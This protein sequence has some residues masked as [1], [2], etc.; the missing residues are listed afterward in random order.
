MINRRHTR[1]QRGAH[2]VEL[3]AALVFG[4]PLLILII[5]VALECT[6]FYAIK[7][8]MD[9]GARNAARALVIDYNK[10]GVQGTNSNLKWLKIPNYIADPGQF[11]DVTW[12]NSN[13]PPTYVTVTCTYFSDGRYGLPQFPRGPLRYLFNGNPQNATFSLGSMNVQG[14]FTIPVQ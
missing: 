13:N 3:A 8:A 7:A 9:V 10:T 6:H 1:N 14:T 12:D 11:T 5:F 4:L 2:L